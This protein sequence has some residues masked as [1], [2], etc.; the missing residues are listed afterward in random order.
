MYL[1]KKWAEIEAERKLDIQEKKLRCVFLPPEA[2][3]SA[4]RSDSPGEEGPPSYERN[5]SESDAALLEK[6]W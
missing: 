2:N 3:S 6:V 1:F 4:I 5:E